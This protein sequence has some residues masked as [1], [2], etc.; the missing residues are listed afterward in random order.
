MD[1]RARLLDPTL[2]E[3]YRT[4]GDA[5]L[6]SRKRRRGG[7]RLALFGALVLSAASCQTVP[8]TGRVAPNGFS[9]EQDVQL[10]TEAYEDMMSQEPLLDS[11][12]EYEMV[13]RVMDRLVAAAGEYD[14]GYPWEVR[15]IDNS[16]VVNAFALPGGKM[17]VY[18]GIL[19]VAQGETGLAV[20]MGH[21]I[22]HVLARHGTE[23]LTSSGAVRTVLDLLFEGNAHALAGQLAG[24]LQL[25]YGRNQELESDHIG[26]IL[27][28]KA[29]YDPT[30]AEGF[31]QR[32]AA[33]GG[34]EPPEWLSTHPSNNRRIDEIRRLLP[35]A[36]E[37]YEAGQGL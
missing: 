6:E 36:R 21:E 9:V 10:G 23:R 15:V 5:R 26:L 27:M 3:L 19:P 17:A 29:G 8:I 34:G 32:M 4:S 18:T 1:T 16:Q 30:A 33:L 20:V 22:G 11:G 12:P 35:E 37:Y 2:P 25:G 13:N 7:T 31:W 14:P 24:V 28:A